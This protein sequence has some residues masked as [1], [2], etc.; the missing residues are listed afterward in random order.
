M[1]DEADEATLDI[2][3]SLDLKAALLHTQSGR[4]TA[5]RSIAH[6]L[7]FTGRTLGQGMFGH[8]RL[9][10]DRKSQTLFAVKTVAK[11]TAGA[12]HLKRR[13]VDEVA[14]HLE[15]DHPRIATLRR[16]YDSPETCDLVM[17]FF[18]GGSLASRLQRQ[19]KFAEPQ[20]AETVRQMLS[21]VSYLHEHRTAH[22]DLKPDNMMYERC[23]SDHLRLIDFGFAVCFEPNQ[24]R[25]QSVARGNV[26][27]RMTSDAPPLGAVVC[28]LSES[29]HFALFIC[30]A[31]PFF[32]ALLY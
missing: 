19:R 22:M 29:Q 30:S 28:G 15:L 23:G 31:A 17:D 3:S 2:C 9:A 32:V 11:G 12:A 24:R 14:V 20:A 21:A 4:Y 13:V 5:V 25:C 1:A 18:E 10:S 6:D 27:C 8:V 16:V 26:R 7:E